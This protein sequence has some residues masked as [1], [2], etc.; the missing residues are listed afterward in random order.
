LQKYFDD[1]LND[2][3]KPTVASWFVS[4]ANGT[5]VAAA[6][7]PQP[8]TSTIG[9]NYARRTYFN[10]LTEEQPEGWHP[11]PGKHIQKTIISAAFRS[12]ATI[13]WKVAISTPVKDKDN[14]F[15]GVVA[16]TVEMGKFLREFHND[17]MR[18]AILV[19]GREG[20]RKGLVLQHPLFEELLAQNTPLPEEFGEARVSLDDANGDQAKPQSDYR[21]PL[22]K[23]KLGQ[24]YAGRWIMAKAPV[25]RR[26]G[27]PDAS[28]DPT[29]MPT[30]WVVLVLEDH[31]TVIKPVHNLGDSLVRQGVQG[32]VAVAVTIATLWY[33]VV[34]WMGESNAAAAKRGSS[35][36]SE[37][38]PRPGRATVRSRG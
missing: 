23:H 31:N 29:L 36:N 11:E 37:A 35:A 38:T 28:G 24:A 3:R 1:L 30:G 14:N 2:D 15:L 21:D 16:L 27:P 10:G 26:D 13:T 5:Q 7:N 22:G 12:D 33:L 6:F 34:R 18:Y 4:D 17:K 25:K 9:R 32:L 20:P 19:D 8:T